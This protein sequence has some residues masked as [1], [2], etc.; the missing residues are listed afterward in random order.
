M[1]DGRSAVEKYDI[2]F[3]KKIRLESE[4]EYAELLWERLVE[5][6]KVRMISDVPLGAFLSGGIDSSTLVGIMSG[7]SRVPVKTFSV[8]F[9]EESFSELKYAKIVAK[10]FGTEHRIQGETRRDRNTS[11]CL[12]L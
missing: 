10:R 8:G 7:I 1:R 11:V 4:Y 6:T 12:A 3:T 2:D 5:A 9:D